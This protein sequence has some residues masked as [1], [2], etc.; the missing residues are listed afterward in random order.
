MVIGGTFVGGN[1]A[2]MALRVGAVIA[3]KPLATT[4]AP[5]PSHAFPTFR[6]EYTSKSMLAA[7]KTVTKP[8]AAPGT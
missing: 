8:I 2:P 3:N 5:A 6:R 7:T 4:S 1:G